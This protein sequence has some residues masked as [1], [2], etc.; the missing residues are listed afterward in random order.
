MIET[1]DVIEI[2]TGIAKLLE[3]S[4]EH[5]RRLGKVETFIEDKAVTKEDLSNLD[6][7]V[8]KVEGNFTWTVRSIV[9]LVFAGVAGMLGIKG[10]H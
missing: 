8:K 9:A 10:G 1:S 2:K 6:D 7:R 4:E 3:R 5:G